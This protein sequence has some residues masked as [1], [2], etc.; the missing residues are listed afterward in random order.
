[1]K[2]LL[3]PA[4]VF[5][6]GPAGI[7]ARE[8]GVDVVV[9]DSVVTPSDKA[10]GEGIMPGGWRPRAGLESNCRTPTDSVFAALVFMRA[11]IRYKPISRTAGVWV[12]G[13]AVA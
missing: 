12:C 4:D 6:I 11:A 5:V 2:P 8:R 9:A 1:M 13:A 10:C 7:A 3:A